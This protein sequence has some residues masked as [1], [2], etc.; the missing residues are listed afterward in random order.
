MVCAA[1]KP[2]QPFY[3]FKGGSYLTFRVAFGIE[4]SSCYPFD[5]HFFIFAANFFPFWGNL[6]RGYVYLMHSFCLLSPLFL[7]EQ[8]DGRLSYFDIGIVWTW[9]TPKLLSIPYDLLTCPSCI[10]CSN[11][12]FS[13]SQLKIFL[14]GEKISKAP[15]AFMIWGGHCGGLTGLHA[16]RPP[17]S[18]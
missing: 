3:R 11:N 15:W 13:L 1:F 14:S 17:S 7:W 2:P 12:R 16:P 4:S 9:H 6:K 5:L 10:P 8:A 18:Y